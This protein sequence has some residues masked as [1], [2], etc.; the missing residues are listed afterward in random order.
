MV[1]YTIDRGYKMVIF[2]T[3]IG[4]LAKDV[5][6]IF[7][8]IKFKANLYKIRNKTGNRDFKYQVRLS[9]N[10]EQFLNLVKPDKS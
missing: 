5:L 8:S 7:N 3:V 2:S 6:D 9:R 10:V 4:N 1:P